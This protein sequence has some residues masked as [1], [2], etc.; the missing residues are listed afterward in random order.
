MGAGAKLTAMGRSL[1]ILLVLA[2]FAA[3][4]AA[5]DGELAK[6]KEQEL[7]EVRGRIS[8]LKKSMDRRAA[9]RDRISK[10]IPCEG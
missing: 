9:E 7:E 6:I 4:S 10:E 2:L 1:L 3:P 8:D 5:Q